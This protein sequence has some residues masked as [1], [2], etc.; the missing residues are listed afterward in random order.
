MRQE[1]SERNHA[2]GRVLER[3]MEMLFRWP[4]EYGGGMMME[5]QPPE[6]RGPGEM[7]AKQQS[8]GELAEGSI[9]DPDDREDVRLMLLAGQGDM[10]AFGQLV[11]RHQHAV[12]GTIAKMI[13]SP[14]GAEDLA[15]QVFVRVWRAAP[16]YERRAKFTTWLFTILRNLVFNE[17]RR[18]KRRPE[19]SLEVEMG[20]E[21]GGVRR[22]VVDPGALSADEEMHQLELERAVAVAIA[23]LPEKQRLAVLLR[24]D[25][26]M[27]YEEIAEVLG[28]SVSAVKS[29]LFR[30]RTSLK[31]KLSGWV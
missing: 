20:G 29:Q 8:A 7:G 26:D 10:V 21:D 12:V 1:A 25:Q 3:V 6:G 19:V 31:E 27:P 2:V 9:D 24:R 15:Q 23:E 16:R 5:A 28:L 30:A 11:G 13:G 18:R 22:E 14:E 17:T 4:V